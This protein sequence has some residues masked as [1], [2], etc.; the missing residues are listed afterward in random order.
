MKIG[1]FS[2]MH[3]GPYGDRV[4]PSNGL[5]ARMM[6]YRDT[7][8]R[9][10]SDMRHVHGVD[11]IL[12]GGDMFKDKSGKP[13]PTQI[14]LVGSVFHDFGVFNGEP[15]TLMITGNHDLPRAS[16]EANALDCLNWIPRIMVV[17]KIC[18][19][20]N[21]GI[22]YILLPYPNR[23]AFM[24]HEQ[25]K[26]MSIHEANETIQAL[27]V[28]ELHSLASKLDPNKPS[29]LLAHV[30]LA[31]S[32]AGSE[33]MMMMGRDI[34]L[35]VSDIPDNIDWCFF[36]HIHKPQMLSRTLNADGSCNFIGSIRQEKQ[37]VHVIGSPESVDFGE[38]GETKRWLLL[39]TDKGTVESIPTNSRKYLT[40]KICNNADIIEQLEP[41][42]SP[43]EGLFVN[44]RDKVKD[45]IVRVKL[46]LRKNE[47]VDISRIRNDIM[48]AGAF[49]VKL[50]R[51]YIP[52][53]RDTSQGEQSGIESQ[54]QED[55]LKEYC[56]TKNITGE[57]AGKMVASG[58]QVMQEVGE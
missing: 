54:T 15:N 43:S 30:A 51:E 18:L 24:A 11:Q 44:M 27:L 3:M 22:Q 25:F 1:I 17:S 53:D 23:N 31:E 46:L 29:I 33:N 9:I 6:D 37:Y 2:D 19:I 41:D 56:K 12:F 14:K 26:D 5:N 7:L 16:G 4:L 47:Q 36:G 20:E 32:K 58:V 34:C 38:E 28:E 8:A 42:Y 39:D 49:S 48:D 52:E 50:E 13:N 40:V 21:C 45:A 35:S 55:I 57:R 10:I